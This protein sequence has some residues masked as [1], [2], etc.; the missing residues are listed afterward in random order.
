MDGGVLG[1]LGEEEDADGRAVLAV[2]QFSVEGRLVADDKDVRA[3][4]QHKRVPIVVRVA[5]Y[6]TNK[7]FGSVN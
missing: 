4:V 7:H 2:H 6:N 5:P 1:E 3:G